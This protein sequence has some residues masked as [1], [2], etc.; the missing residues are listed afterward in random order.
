MESSVELSGEVTD[1]LEEIITGSVVSSGCEVMESSVE[2]SG[3]V[4][5]ATGSSIFLAVGSDLRV[6][7]DSE[8]FSSSVG[9]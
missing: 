7:S 2:L 3:G 4:S 6:L 5:L 8:L 9:S 1:S